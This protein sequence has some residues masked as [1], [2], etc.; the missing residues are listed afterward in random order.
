MIWLPS[1]AKVRAHRARHRRRRLWGRSFDRTRRRSLRERRIVILPGQYFDE[2]T[3]LSYNYFRDY[4]ATIGRYVESDPIG[5]DGGM[6]TYLYV[7]G[8]PS[9]FFDPPGLDVRV[10]PP[11]A[12]ALYQQAVKYLSRDPGM[13]KIIKYLETSPERYY[14]QIVHNGNDLFHLQTNTIDWDPNSAV[15]VY[16]KSESL[17]C[18]ENDTQTPAL[19]LGHEMAHAA[20]NTLLLYLGYELKFPKGYPNYE[21]WRVVR[22]PERTAAKTLGEGIRD[23]LRGFPYNVSTPTAR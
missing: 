22:G 12:S 18:T 15:A 14:V 13:Q 17:V 1:N 16:N 23:N 11:D 9:K 5:L 10:S 20:R 7:S 6:N 8:N 2:E 3:G 4:D 21:E 19:G